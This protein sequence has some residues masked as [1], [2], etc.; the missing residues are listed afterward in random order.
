MKISQ[1]KTCA[2]CKALR[3]EPGFGVSCSL[4][5]A[6]DPDKETP[7][8]PCPKPMTLTDFCTIKIQSTKSIP[9]DADPEPIN[10][11]IPIFEENPDIK[12]VVHSQPKRYLIDTENI[13]RDWIP[14][15][16]QQEPNT[17]YILFY[18]TYSPTIPL[19]LFPVLI[20]AVDCIEFVNCV[21]SGKNA[22]DFQLVSLLGSMLTQNPNC[23]YIITS[24]D[25]GY[26]AVV[27]FW[28]QKGID[29]SR[30][31]P[32]HVPVL[33][34]DT[35]PNQTSSNAP[36]ATISKHEPAYRQVYLDHLKGAGLNQTTAE[37]V[38][39]LICM[40]INKAQN[41]RKAAIY[42]A[43][44]QVFG[45]LTGQQIYQEAKSTIAQ[46]CKNGPFPKH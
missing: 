17:K 22:L 24:K 46:F 6:I 3:R 33:V 36:A 11:V 25:Q 35:G 30:Y 38:A 7:S 10:D 29:V 43:I 31:A 44:L 2:R 4:G 34:S 23:K 13:G 37:I 16:L 45:Q 19:S 8:E 12:A 28:Q 21:P 5:Y 39:N 40:H 15:V 1:K 27:S 42:E 32:P 18:T 41:K 20:H 9:A 14:L 26:D